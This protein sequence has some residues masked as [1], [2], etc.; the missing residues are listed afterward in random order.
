M[1]LLLKLMLP[2]KINYIASLKAYVT[3]TVAVSCFASQ[4]EVALI[5]VSETGPSLWLVF[6][7]SHSRH[8]NRV[9]VIQ[10]VFK[11][12]LCIKDQFFDSNRIS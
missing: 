7:L 12:C 5:S 2:M 10:T 9:P 6:F 3:L 11:Q 1:I 8:S 4:S